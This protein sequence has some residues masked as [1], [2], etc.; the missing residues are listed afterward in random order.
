MRLLPA[1]TT[2][3]LRAWLPEQ[4]APLWPLALA[5]VLMGL[6]WLLSLRWKLPPDF[7]GGSERR[8]NEWLELE[9]EHPVV[10]LYATMIDS[11]VL[12]N[13]TA[14]AWMIFLVELAVGL[15]LLT[16]TLTR[17][18][19]LVGLLLSLNLGIGLAAVPGEWPW[20]Y[21]MMAMWHGTLL[22]AGAGRLWGVDQRL[23]HALAPDSS[24]RSLI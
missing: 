1:A 12:P 2:E 5:R 19:A 20:A 8:L 11:I 6:L 18:G 7:D 22:V 24:L 23:H 10:G 3:R 13:F 15:S 17:A 16:G 21:A 9:V 14:F 4:Q